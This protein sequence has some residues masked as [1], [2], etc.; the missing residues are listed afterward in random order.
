[1]SGRGAWI[2]QRCWRESSRRTSCRCSCGRRRKVTAFNP[3]GRLARQILEWL[4]VDATGPRPS[5]RPAP[6]RARS[7]S[8]CIRRTRAWIRSTRTEPALVP[9]E[10]VGRSQSPL[11]TTAGFAQLQRQIRFAEQP[12]TGA[13]ERESSVSAT[14]LTLGWSREK[15]SRSSFLGADEVEKSPLAH[16][17]EVRRVRARLGFRAAGGRGH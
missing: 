11:L 5:P 2:G 1:M 4:G 16:C 9:G 14:I 7:T 8:T 13:K 12:D 6:G 10:P 17:R 3:S 15:A